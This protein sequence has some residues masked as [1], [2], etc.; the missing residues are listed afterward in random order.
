MGA[1]LD[2]VRRLAGTQDNGDRSAAL[3][4]VDVDRQEAAFVVVGVEKRKLLISVH[5]VDRVVDVERD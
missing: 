1:H 2:A 4:V 5:H 3:G